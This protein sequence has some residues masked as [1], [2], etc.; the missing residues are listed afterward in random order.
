MD[1]LETLATVS[2]RHRTQD[3]DKKKP[4]KKP[5]TKNPPTHNTEN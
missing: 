2:T 3:E 4:I 5:K 1:N